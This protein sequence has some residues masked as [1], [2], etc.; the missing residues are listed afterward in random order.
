MSIGHP[1]FCL[2]TSL[3]HL[4]ILI[5]WGVVLSLGFFINSRY[6][7]PA[8]RIVG[9]GFLP[10]WSL[11]LHSADA[12]LCCLEISILY[13]TL[14]NSWYFSVLLESFWERLS[15]FLKIYHLWVFFSRNFRVSHLT[16]CLFVYF[17]LFILCEIYESSFINLHI[18]IQFFQH[19]LLTSSQHRLKNRNHMIVS[20]NARNVF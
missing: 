2:F 13:N 10:F 7:S 8:R 20:I 6:Q 14:V 5:I 18:D 1:Y 19:H 11:P 16:S 9:K 17:E 15:L 3:A 4:L 12:F